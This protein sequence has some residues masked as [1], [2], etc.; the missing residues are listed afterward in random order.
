MRAVFIG[1]DYSMGFRYGKEYKIKTWIE[2][3]FF[4]KKGYLWVKDINSNLYCL[5]SR[6]ETFLKNWKIIKEV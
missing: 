4:T 6:V 5:Y 3:R 1:K 2:S